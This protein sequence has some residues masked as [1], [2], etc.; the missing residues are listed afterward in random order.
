MKFKHVLFMMISLAWWPAFGW[1]QTEGFKVGGEIIFKKNGDLYIQLM[2]QEEF[3]GDKEPPFKLI[4]QVGAEEIK[5]GKV[6]FIFQK[7]PHGMYGIRCFQ[8]VNGNKKLDMGPFGPKEPW[9]VYRPKRPT[10]R[11]PKFEESAFEVR[12]DITDIQLEVK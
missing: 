1:T 12:K 9:G 6:P 2:T 7:V 10:F 8:D 5:K 4:I 11:S 3:A